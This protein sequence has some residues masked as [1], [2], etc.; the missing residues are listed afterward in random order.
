MI[1][2]DSRVIAG[3]NKVYFSLLP[4]GLPGGDQVD[5]LPP[6][7]S[8]REEVGRDI[9]LWLVEQD[10]GKL[11]LESNDREEV[12]RSIPLCSYY[13]K[14]MTERTWPRGSRGK[15]TFL[16]PLPAGNTGPRYL[17][18]RTTKELFGNLGQFFWKSWVFLALAPTFQ[19][20]FESILILRRRM[21]EDLLLY[22]L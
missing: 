7:A 12:G 11:L 13:Q 19:I 2:N 18:A 17:D 5:G 14:V 15:H 4:L 3:S 20:L 6:A 21:Q 8:D 10:Y 22:S 9:P 1:S 16:L